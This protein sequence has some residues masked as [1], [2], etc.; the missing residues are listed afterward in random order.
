MERT[1]DAIEAFQQGIQEGQS[2]FIKL[3]NKYCGFDAKN[4]PEVIHA[5]NALK[6]ES[7]EN[8]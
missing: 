1:V 7:H 3:V 2:I 4:I 5:I 6:E 8:H